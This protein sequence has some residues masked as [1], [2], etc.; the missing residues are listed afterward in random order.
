MEVIWRCALAAPARHSREMSAFP[1][2]PESRLEAL[3]SWLE[4]PSLRQPTTKPLLAR[5][6]C[7]QDLPSRDVPVLSC[8]PQGLRR[9]MLR[10]LAQL[11]F[12]V[13]PGPRAVQEAI[14]CWCRETRR[15]V[16]EAFQ[17]RPGHRLEAPAKQGRHLED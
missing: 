5:S 16:Q 3:R 4:I 8:S 10:N 15:F 7:A 1:L 6:R 9:G 17:F 11:S 12:E 14:C 13:E 2:H